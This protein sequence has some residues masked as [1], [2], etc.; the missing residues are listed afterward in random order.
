M[1]RP[2]ISFPEGLLSIIQW[3]KGPLILRTKRNARLWAKSGFRPY[4]LPA[5]NMT[6]VLDF[7]QSSSRKPWRSVSFSSLRGNRLFSDWHWVHC[8]G[9]FEFSWQLSRKSRL[10]IFVIL[11]LISFYTPGSKCPC[12]QKGPQLHRMLW[13]AEDIVKH[14]PVSRLSGIATRICYWKKRTWSNSI[15]SL[16]GNSIT[17]FFLDDTFVKKS[18]K[19]QAT[20]QFYSHWNMTHT[21]ALSFWNLK[22]AWAKSTNWF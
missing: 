4:L 10:L 9:S 19:L 22:W 6:G 14:C 2:N 7:L 13:D 11:N 8:Q 12:Q 1:T 15:S 21:C 3:K 5:Q 20:R 16:F 18:W 17:A